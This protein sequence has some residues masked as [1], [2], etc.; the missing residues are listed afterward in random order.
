[1][2]T[3][4]KKTY[5]KPQMEAILIQNQQALLTGSNFSTDVIDRIDE[6]DEIGD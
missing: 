2:N 5:T 6:G 3:I 1:M 4:T